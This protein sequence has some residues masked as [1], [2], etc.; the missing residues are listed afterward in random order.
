MLLGGPS[1]PVRKEIIVEAVSCQLCL[2]D[3]SYVLFHTLTVSEQVNLKCC[4]VSQGW[5]LVGHAAV[6][7]G[8]LICTQLPNY[9]I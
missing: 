5:L 8:E 1:L 9:C 2:R 3:G 7:W 4:S 6:L